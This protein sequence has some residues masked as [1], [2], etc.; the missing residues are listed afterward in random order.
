ME[1]CIF[2][3]I[4]AGEIPSD[5]VYEDDMM[6]AFKD[7]SPAAP[8]HVLLV[9]KKHTDSIVTADKEVVAYMM[10]KVGAIA[11]SLGLEERGFRLVTNKGLEAGQSVNH[12]HFHLIGGKEL[13]WPPC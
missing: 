13:G 4:I 11:S 10:N 1:E 6:I 12:L 8:V 7:V 3:K 9:P 5:K 2:C